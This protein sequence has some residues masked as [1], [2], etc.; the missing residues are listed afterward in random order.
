MR[1]RLEACR[2][3][4]DSFHQHIQSRCC[5]VF[6][7]QQ[8][9]RVKQLQ[10]SAVHDRKRLLRSPPLLPAPDSTSGSAQTKAATVAIAPCKVHV[11]KASG[12]DF[13]QVLA[14]CTTLVAL[15]VDVL[16]LVLHF[17][18]GRVTRVQTFAHHP[19][20]HHCRN[21]ERGARQFLLVTQVEELCRR[22]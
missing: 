8:T 18:R 5:C 12:I 7:V 13:K 22:K 16:Q 15:R 14:V 10:V 4:L 19:P 2:V 6:A 20:A 17:P 1:A 21:L 9:R 11:L 3:D